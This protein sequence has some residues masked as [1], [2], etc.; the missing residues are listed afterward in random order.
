[1]A[2]LV[3]DMLGELGYDVIRTAGA[4]A[5]LGALAD[6]RR[7]D[8]IFSDL[9]MPGRMNGL[10]LVREARRRRPGLAVLLTSGYADAAMREAGREDINVLRKPYDIQTLAEAIGEAFK[11]G[12]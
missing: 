9:M 2:S 12:D 8:L 6:G 3:T 4:D 7:V 1:M 5:A 11:G 10:D